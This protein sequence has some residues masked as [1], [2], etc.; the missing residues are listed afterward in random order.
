M[1]RRPVCTSRLS[2]FRQLISHEFLSGLSNLSISCRLSASN[3]LPFYRRCL[4]TF[5]SRLLTSLLMRPLSR[6]R[7]GRSPV[8]GGAP[9][10]WTTW[11]VL[12]TPSVMRVR[13]V[14]S[15]ASTALLNSTMRR[16]M[17]VR[18]IWPCL[19][20]AGP[21]VVIR[22][23]VPRPTTLVVFSRVFL[24]PRLRFCLCHLV[25]VLPLWPVMP[26]RCCRN[27]PGLRRTGLLQ[28]TTSGSRAVFSPHGIVLVASPRSVLL[29]LLPR[30]LFI[31]LGQ[32]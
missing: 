10:F 24:L 25:R 15:F 23:A 21:R 1:F 22:F 20:P 31:A 26:L 14:L 32:A 18:P 19:L 12:A 8:V 28:G 16:R 5:P 13:P 11:S 17:R 9:R 2:A 29:M 30:S 4:L 3:L 27:R 6:S 7:R